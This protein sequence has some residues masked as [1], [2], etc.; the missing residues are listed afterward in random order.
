MERK[1]V[2]GD[3]RPEVQASCKDRRHLLIELHLLEVALAFPLLGPV[4]QECCRLGD[5]SLA[6]ALVTVG[7][8]E[9]IRCAPLC[10]V[11]GMLDE[12]V[13]VIMRYLNDHTRSVDFLARLLNMNLDL[14][15]GRVTRLDGVYNVFRSGH[16]WAPRSF[17]GPRRRVLST[18]REQALPRLQPR[19][20]G[21]NSGDGV[22]F[23]DVLEGGVAGV[24]GGV[25]EDA[26]AEEVHSGV[27]ELGSDTVDDVVE[28]FR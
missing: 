26:G 22:G 10:A 28:L 9:C 27:E 7:A 2:S 5:H 20:R 17:A 8:N 12:W 3:P 14:Q 4:F 18:R 19:L 1:T 16:V 6:L 13:R 23:A 21:G 15:E 25:A 24:T 11:G